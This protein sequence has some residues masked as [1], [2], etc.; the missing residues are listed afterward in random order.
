MGK[1]NDIFSKVVTT[2]VYAYFVLTLVGN[3]SIGLGQQHPIDLY[4]PV[5]IVFKLI[6]MVGWLKVAQAIEKPFDEDDAD[7]EMYLLVKR[8]IRVKAIF[9]NVVS[10]IK[11]IPQATNVIL[12]EFDDVPGAL[13]KILQEHHHG[14]PGIGDGGQETEGSGGEG[15]KEAPSFD[16]SRLPPIHQGRTDGNGWRRQDSRGFRGAGGG[17]V[18]ED[19]LSQLRDYN[20]P[21][22]NYH[23]QNDRR[24][25]LQI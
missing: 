6:L 2:A 14:K 9:K 23:Q 13:G 16:G 4:F 19:K 25:G 1:F 21:L 17:G 11:K 8:H 20:F 15:Q 24:C 22:Q 12:N 3:Q 5:F 7:F 10:R 18:S